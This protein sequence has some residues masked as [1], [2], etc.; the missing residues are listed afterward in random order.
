M[1]R[2]RKH[3]Y[4]TI[5]FWEKKPF[6]VSILLPSSSLHSMSKNNTDNWGKRKFLV[7]PTIFVQGW[8]KNEKSRKKDILSMWIQNKFVVILVIYYA[9][10]NKGTPSVSKICSRKGKQQ[11]IQNETHVQHDS[12]ELKTKHPQISTFYTHAHSKQLF[13]GHLYDACAKTSDIVLIKI[14][15]SAWS[16]N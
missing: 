7:F 5:Y 1:K 4:Y 8:G 9:L 3:F 2:K 11:I 16:R 15:R 14:M 10:W 13:T 6:P 12:T